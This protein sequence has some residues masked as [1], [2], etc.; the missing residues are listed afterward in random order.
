MTA[1]TNALD[2]G[3]GLILVEPGD[4]YRTRWSVTVT[5]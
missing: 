5:P 2:S 4:E 1:P 3:D